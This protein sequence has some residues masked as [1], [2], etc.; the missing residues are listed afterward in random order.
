MTCSYEDPVL[1]DIIQH[2]FFEEVAKFAL[3]ADEVEFFQTAITMAYP[4]PNTPFSFEQH[5]DIQYCLS[6]FQAI[7]RRMICSYFLWL[8]DV[9]D[10]RAPMMYR[11]GSHLLLA[12]AREHDPNLRGVVPKVEVVAQANLPALNYAEAIPIT[13]K[14]G[15]VS[16]LT[17]STVHGASVN[18][19]TEPRSVLVITFTP[20]GVTIGLP[21]NQEAQRLAYNQELR[22][23]LRPNRVHII[24]N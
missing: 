8:S 10:R 21:P 15:Q 5:V 1:L 19:D 7:P 17:T 11:P 4:Q 20:A 24:P 6:D 13:A 14:A 23:H 2:P 9:N 22:Q 18:V 12:E 3:E 16:V